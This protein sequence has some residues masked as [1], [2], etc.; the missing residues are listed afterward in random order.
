MAA[1]MSP[2]IFSFP[3]MYAVVGFC[4]PATIFSKF[5]SLVEKVRVGVAGALGDGDGAVRDR[6]RPHAGALD[7]EDVG[8]VHPLDAVGA[9]PGRKPLEELLNA[10]HRVGPSSSLANGRSLS[11]G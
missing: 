11:R 2:L 1:P 4:S 10:A 9:D 6:H 8:V 5:S 7:V 3:V